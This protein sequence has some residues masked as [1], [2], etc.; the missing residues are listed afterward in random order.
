MASATAWKTTSGNYGISKCPA[1]EV[2]STFDKES[3]YATIPAVMEE[4][5]A[6]IATDYEPI[7]AAIPA[8][9]QEEESSYVAVPDACTLESKFDMEMPQPHP[10]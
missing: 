10:L 6:V 7:Y 4:D 3:H 2:H 9:K 1:Y 5:Y 8:L